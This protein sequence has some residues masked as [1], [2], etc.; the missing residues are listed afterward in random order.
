MLMDHSYDGLMADLGPRRRARIDGLTTVAAPP[1]EEL[2][3]YPGLVAGHG[4]SAL[5]TVSPPRDHPHAVTPW[6]CSPDAA[7]PGR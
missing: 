6:S 4:F 5:V 2:R 1:Y 7:T 3:T